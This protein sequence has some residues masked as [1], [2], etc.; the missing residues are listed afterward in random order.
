VLTDLGTPCRS[1]PFVLC[2]IRVLE[3]LLDLIHQG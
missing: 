3:E 1:R 2:R